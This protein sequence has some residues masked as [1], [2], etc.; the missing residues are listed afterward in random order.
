VSRALGRAG[1]VVLVV[2]L[3]LAGRA[4]T[5]AADDAATKHV[6]LIDVPGAS[7]EE[8]LG[9]REIAS[10]ARW[11]GAALMSLQ[12][13]VEPYPSYPQ[14]DPGGMSAITDWEMDPATMGGLGAVG[15]AVRERVEGVS[16]DEVLV[17]IMSRTGSAQMA[18]EKDDLHPIVMAIGAP[19]DVFVAGGES[20]SLT[21]DTTRRTGVV[22]DLDVNPTV[23][24]FLDA[25][26]FDEEGSPIRAVDDPAPFALHERYLAQRRMYVPIGTA[27]ALYLTAVGLLG[28]GFVA[29]RR[30]GPRDVRRAVGWACLSVALLTTGMLAA[31]H[32]PEPTYATVVPFIAIVTVLGTMA[33]SPLERTSPVLVP[34]GIGSVVLAFFA[35]EAVLGWSAML[36]PML[37]GTHLDGGRFYGLPNVAIGLLVGAS[38]WVAQRLETW[39][40]VGLLVVVAL[41]AGMPYAGSNLGGGVTLFATAGMWLAV[42][43]R[44]RLGAWKGIGAVALF[45]VAGTGLILLAHRLAPLPTHITRFEEAAGGLGGV[46]ETFVDRLGVGLDLIRGNPAAL[47]PV[48]GLPLALLAVLRP[49]ASVRSTFERWPVWRDA[50]LVSLL[51]GVVAYFANDTGPAAAGL[52]FGLGLGG[53]LGVSLLAGPGKMDG[54]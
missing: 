26:G 34:A 39:P 5:A 22:T 18:A 49:P 46:W 13:H 11:G 12:K 48:V 28:V 47:V 4:S 31:G 52:A 3:L 27:A 45:T 44:A 23:G 1:L 42:R 29:F 36:T 38:L 21:S 43:E 51:A 35:V 15:A 17:I 24:E 8:L 7:F 40:G 14:V 20:G 54:S 41:L 25:P 6:F 37:G 33:F 19:E 9:V 53:M 50:V 16:A 32:L 30:L 10:L 2:P